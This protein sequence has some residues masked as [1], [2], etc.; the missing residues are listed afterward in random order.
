MDDTNRKMEGIIMSFFKYIKNQYIK[1]VKY[2]KKYKMPALFSFQ[3]VDYLDEYDRWVYKLP[4]P[5]PLKMLDIGSDYGS[6]YYY[7]RYHNYD[8]V[9]YKPYD[10]LIFRPFTNNNYAELFQD[11]DFIKIDCEGC[12]FEIFKN[13]DLNL[14]DK[15]KIYA[16]AV[17]KNGLYD[18]EV[19]TK[20]KSFCKYKIF[21]VNEEE[22]YTNRTR[23]GER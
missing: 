22:I 5:N 8:I 16:I 14:L 11:Y 4:L 18:E 23:E 12:E 19:V 10:Y 21:T 3:F 13:M 2:Y 17:H 20:I 9:K 1:P 7:L 15:N 6:L